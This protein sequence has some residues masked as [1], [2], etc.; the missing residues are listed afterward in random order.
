MN[1][2]TD[3]LTRLESFI[4]DSTGEHQRAQQ[5]LREID[6]LIRQS[7]AE[8]ERLAQRNTQIRGKVAAMEQDMENYA[9]AE[10]RSLYNAE[11]ESQLRLF[12]MRSQVEQ[13]QNK[14][15][16]L[17]K[18]VQELQRF[19]DLAHI[20]PAKE[21]LSLEDGGEQRKLPGGSTPSMA[22]VI[23]AQEEER[24]ALARHM[25]DG[26]AQSLT[27]LVL[28]AE[29]CERLFDSDAVRA[30]QELV[31]LK[32]FA[33]STFQKVRD[34][35]F[36]LRPMMLDDLGL[37]PTL[38]RYIAAFEEKNRIGVHFQ[39]T[40]QERRAPS[41]LEITLFRAVQ[42]LLANAVRHAHATHI[43]VNLD[44]Q[45]DTAVVVVEDNGSGFDVSEAMAPGRKQRSGV[46]LTA[47]RERV[48]MLG[49]EVAFDSAV[50]R[51]TRI[52]IAIPIVVEEVGAA[53][54]V[55]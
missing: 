32:N 15:R 1:Q 19:M 17:E 9:R 52:T 33:N 31:N 46:G 24:Q 42:E 10:I 30:K 48:E 37:A 34:F 12:M 27:N 54:A 8:V 50:G 40:G 55:T 13:L 22:R 5:E 16:T 26:P 28:H 45:N 2:S 21:E 7:T 4:A 3:F 14:Q 43:Q 39:L 36:E 41:A 6:L 23:E 18:Y 53:L 38:R 49:G 44:L 29:I 20:M 25:H 51:G 11:R 35:I 47:L